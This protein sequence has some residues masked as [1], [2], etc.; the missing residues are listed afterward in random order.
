MRELF[1]DR[2]STLPEAALLLDAGGRPLSWVGQFQDVTERRRQEA[3][4][5]HLAEHDP[6]TGLLN[7]SAFALALEQHLARVR[8]YGGEGALLMADLDGFKRVNDLHGHAAGDELL[9]ACAD[10]LRG[11]LRESDA[12]AR[13]GGDEFAV[14][15]RGGGSEEA[16][17]VARSLLAAVEHATL[18]AITASVGVASVGAGACRADELL[19]GADRA[20]YRAKRAGGGAF[21]TCD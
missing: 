18:G 7:R 9:T 15:L 19:R 16:E 6:L 12:I 5:R 3:E 2:L 13:L 21:A 8:R 20:M 14:L 17:I 1:A 4:L 10:A 11:R